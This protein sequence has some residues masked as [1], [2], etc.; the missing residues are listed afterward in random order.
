MLGVCF[1]Q[2]ERLYRFAR[3]LF[4]VEVERREEMGRV[5]PRE[6]VEAHNYALQ[7]S[8]L[9][10]EVSR[11]SEAALLQWPPADALA[12]H[13]FAVPANWYLMTHVDDSLRAHVLPGYS[14]F[15]DSLAG[16][17]L[18]SSEIASA[19]QMALTAC[20]NYGGKRGGLA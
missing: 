19:L 8:I 6:L 18:P 14:V 10:L 15:S 7:R 5:G 4:W 11:Q 2:V 3:H 9:L 20:L 17:F 13:P 16:E 12:H 1:A